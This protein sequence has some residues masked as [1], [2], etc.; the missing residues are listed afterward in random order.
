VYIT[1]QASVI[2]FSLLYLAGLLKV[3]PLLLHRPLLGTMTQNVKLNS[4]EENVQAAE[5]NWLVLLS[6][7]AQSLKQQT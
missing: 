3:F 1:D 7:P 6:F 2:P 5:L 4:L